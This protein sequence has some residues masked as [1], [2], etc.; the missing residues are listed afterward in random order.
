[1]NWVRA[2]LCCQ[3][4]PA[5][6]LKHG[7]AVYGILEKSAVHSQEDEQ[8]QRDLETISFQE[9]LKVICFCWTEGDR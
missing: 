1:M 9:S 2:P 3:T 8:V 7:R 5:G 4:S 6:F